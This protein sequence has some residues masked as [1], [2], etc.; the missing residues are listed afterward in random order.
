MGKIINERNFGPSGQDSQEVHLLK[1][2]TPVRHSGSRY[3]LESLHELR[4]ALPP[5]GFHKT[6]DDVCAATQAPMALFEHFV[7]LPDARSCPEVDPQ[8][9][10]TH[11]TSSGR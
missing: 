10:G 7:R 4:N 1:S 3:D 9:S 5:V 2:R 8:L 11:G 6:D